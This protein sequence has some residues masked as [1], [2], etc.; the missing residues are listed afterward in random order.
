VLVFEIIES[1]SREE[2]YS[3]IYERLRF[4]VEYGKDGNVCK[5]NL[6]LQWAL[7]TLKA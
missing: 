7:V 2:G 1:V 4:A 5:R 6:T 3:I